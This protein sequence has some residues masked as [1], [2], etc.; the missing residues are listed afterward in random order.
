MQGGALSESDEICCT[1]ITTKFVSGDR[2][3]KLIINFDGTFVTYKTKTSTDALERGMFQIVEKWKDSEE[4]IWYKI[5]MQ[6][7]NYGTKYK[8]ATISKDGNKLEFVC[9]PDKYSAEIDKNDPNY[10][11]YI[12]YSS[13]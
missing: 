12:R 6:G 11:N 10:C 4:N 13:Y 7:L 1:W 2:P 3:Q 8:L 5:R 9:K